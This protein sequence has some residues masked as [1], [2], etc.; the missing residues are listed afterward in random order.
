MFSGLWPLAVCPSPISPPPSRLLTDDVA[1]H[2]TEGLGEG[3]HHH[4]HVLRVYAAVLARA[5]AGLPQRSYAVRLVEVDVRL[6]SGGGGGGGT[7]LTKK[8]RHA[9]LTAWFRYRSGQNINPFRTAVPI[10]GQTT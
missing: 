9:K 2:A 4:V 8:T 10:W 7:S 5:P 6:E 3:S 1:A